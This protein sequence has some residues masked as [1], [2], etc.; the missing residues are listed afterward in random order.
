MQRAEEATVVL[1]HISGYVDATVRG[2]TNNL[3]AHYRTGK[4]DHDVLV[5]GV[6]EI[7]ALLNMVSHLTVVQRNGEA[8]ASKE[9]GKN[10]TEKKPEATVE[11]TRIGIGT[12]GA[13]FRRAQPS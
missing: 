5:G 8:A 4:I 13:E 6:G 7:N 11:R 10:G 1:G 3:V 2:I 9:F 12:R